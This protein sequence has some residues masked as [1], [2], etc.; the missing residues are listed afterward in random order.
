MRLEGA[1]NYIL[2]SMDTPAGRSRF[3]SESI[4]RSEGS[5][6]S[7]SLLCTN[8][9]FLLTNCKNNQNI[10]KGRPLPKFC[11]F[12]MTKNQVLFILNIIFDFSLGKK[13]I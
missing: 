8:V 7:I 2:I 6:M 10:C 1:R 9:S 3:E 4:V 12:I 5:S 13:E 11:F